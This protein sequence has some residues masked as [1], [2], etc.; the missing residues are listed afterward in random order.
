MFIAAIITCIWFI[1]ALRLIY[2]Y[3]PLMVEDMYNGIKD[4]IK[5]I[6]K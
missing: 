4:I 6:K 2:V 5:D 3:L 1:I